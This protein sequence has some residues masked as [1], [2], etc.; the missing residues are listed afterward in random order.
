MLVGYTGKPD[1]DHVIPG[2]EAGVGVQVFVNIS[3]TQLASLPHPDQLHA[4]SQS[5]GVVGQEVTL[6]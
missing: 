2:L 5:A 1:V 4:A 6:V 3:T